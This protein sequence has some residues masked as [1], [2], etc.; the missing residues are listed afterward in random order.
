[1]SATARLRT[2]G[3]R[4]E[5]GAKTL[6]TVSI[7]GDDPAGQLPRFLDLRRRESSRRM[8]EKAQETIAFATTAPSPIG[9]SAIA[10]MVGMQLQARAAPEDASA[11]DE[12]VLHLAASTTDE[13]AMRAV[14]RGGIS[15]LD[16]CGYGRAS[17][18][19]KN[20]DIDVP[21]G[22]QTPTVDRPQVGGAELAAAGKH[23]LTLQD[24]PWFV[25]GSS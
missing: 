10:L 5:I 13:S 20:E 14:T 11:G 18:G 25:G 23:D 7:R 16:A 22:A 15:E 21:H 8:N 4:V 3:E 24:T 19:R 17:V 2:N 6:E 1:M 12:Q 9:E